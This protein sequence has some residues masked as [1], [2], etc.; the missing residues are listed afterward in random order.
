[1]FSV[2]ST[3]SWEVRLSFVVG[4]SGK[5]VVWVTVRFFSFHES[6]EG[7]KRLTKRASLVWK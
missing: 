7:M 3:G 2:S 1:M 5:A 4:S 6:L